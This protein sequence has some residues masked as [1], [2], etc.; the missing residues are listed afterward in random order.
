VTFSQSLLITLS[1]IL[2]AVGVGIAF[3][4]YWILRSRDRFETLYQHTQ[5]EHESLRVASE[6]RLRKVLDRS[7]EDM[8]EKVENYEALL[9]SERERSRK[10]LSDKKSTEVRTG[11][12][13]EKVAPLFKDF[14]GDIIE[15]NVIPVF[16]TVDY[17]V[18]KDDEIIL[19]E[20][21]SGNAGLSTRQKKLKR[22]VEEGKVSFQI[23]RRRGTKKNTG[24]ENG[25]EK[26]DQE[27]SGG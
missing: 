19:V 23:F 14:P 17:I 18:I 27:S 21:K 10:Y 9:K 12:M 4:I 5:K 25:R 22:L 20:V 8:R 7:Q 24:D 2:I 11:H 1:L 6:N 13:I 15:D 3:L 26:K 16:K